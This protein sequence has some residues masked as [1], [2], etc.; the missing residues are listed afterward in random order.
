MR[1]G[2]RLRR[3]A[4]AVAIFAGVSLAG[5]AGLP[6]AA[7]EPVL[8]GRVTFRGAPV[9]GALVTLY[10]RFAPGGKRAYRT[11]VC[12]EDGGFSTPVAPGTYFVEASGRFEGTDVFAFSGQ[13]PVGVG[14]GDRWLGMK[15]VERETAAATPSAARGTA[16]EGEVVFGGKPVEGASVY[17]YAGPEGLFKGM[18]VAMSPPTGPDGTFA[19]DGLPESAY[20]LVARRRG[21]GGATGP[22]EKG[23]LYGYYPG[24]PVYV[25]D[26][27]VTRV[28]I[29]TVEKEKALSYADVTSGTET[30]LRG[31]VV[32]RAGAPQ[33]GIYAFVYDD[34]V[35]GHQRPYAHSG[36]T[37]PDGAWAIYLDRGGVFYLGARENFGNSPR[38]GER[39]GFYDGTPDHGID[40]APGKGAADLTIVVDRILPE[41]R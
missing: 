15:A 13:N 25:R 11:A 2:P 20:Y 16:L 30:V 12:G 35:F 36:R 19:V 8:S 7:R 24:N 39:F 26:G 5:C 37:G 31:R 33:A 32:N 3:A 29:E 38:P 22:L 34:R 27:T 21:A 14:R 6:R 41:A 10:D 28:M 17:V 40:V 9:P 23:D 1:P 4:L 18:G